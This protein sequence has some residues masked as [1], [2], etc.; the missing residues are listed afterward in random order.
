M[1]ARQNQFTRLFGGAALATIITAI[2]TPGFAQPQAPT[3][4][5]V[6]KPAADD[7]A[8]AEV[9]V[10]G[11]LIR[12]V[13]PVGTNVTGV[14]EQQ[15]QAMGATSPQQILAQIPAVTNQF[16]TAPS[17]PTNIGLSTQRPNIRNLGASGGNTT[18]VLVDGHNLVG[19]GILQTTPDS[20]L[21]PV[22]ALQRVEVMAD[23]GSSLYGADAVGGIV[24][25][26]TKRSADGLEVQGHYG[27]ADPGY[28][29]A[30]LGATAGRSWSN[31]SAYISASHRENSDLVASKRNLPRQDF[32]PFGG[33]DFRATACAAPNITVG[34]VNYAGPGFS[35]GTQNRC[36]AAL[37]SDIVPEEK[38]DSVFAA[39]NQDFGD[40]TNLFVTTYWADR[41]SSVA[42]TQVSATG[43]AIPTTNPFFRPLGPGTAQTASLD[44]APVLGPYSY[45]RGELSEYGVT[46]TLTV[47]LG[48]DWEVKGMINYGRSET[49]VHT[50]SVNASALAA[51]GAGTTTATALNPYD[52]RQTN[53]GVIAAIT[54]FENHG[55]NV[56]ALTEYRVIAEGPVL[57]LPGG[58]V[59]MALGADY[60]HQ[61]SDALSGNNTPGNDSTAATKRASRNVSAVFG[62]VL[63]PI[64]GPDNALP[65]VQA[66]T[67][68]A[69]IRYDDY[70]DFGDTTNPKIG[71][72][73][74][75]AGGVSL[76][77][78]YGTAFNAP[79]LA[80]TTGA[81]DSRAAILSVSP[82]RAPTSP[83]TDLFRPTIVLAGGNP[84]L[85][86]Q[87]ADTWSVGVDWKPSYIA[88]FQ[89][90]LT[91]WDVK[92]DDTIVV[93]PPGFPTSV[94][95]VPA[96]QQ[97]AVV[98]PTLAQAQAITAGMIVD[99][100]PSIASLYTPFSSPYVIL[101]LRRKNVGTL[102]VS[103]L[104]FYANYSRST[105]FGALFAN[106]SGTYAL[107]RESE[108]PSAGRTDL[109]ASNTSRLQVSGTVGATWGQ[110]TASATMNYSAG[111]DVT[112]LGAQTKVDDFHPVNL[113]FIYNFTGDGWGKDLQFT[114]NI[115]NVL[116]DEIPFVNSTSGL[117]SNGRTLGR[118]VNLGI[119]KH[120]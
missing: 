10:T 94:F 34:G 84:D 66:F 114:L 49:E 19:A 87:T 35:A 31:G 80:D 27:L 54:N 55:R 85:K 112:G 57:T 13:A 67:L 33:D 45:S 30:D 65:F 102:Y 113:A 2:S 110:L 78:N 46:P 76:R 109:L 62:Q 77:G 64:V 79:S 24:N 28:W 83:I 72:T 40:R 38:Q 104:D 111:F 93:A 50:P 23:G 58:E 74:E 20:D 36:D 103:G 71:F 18:L 100:A 63:V 99:G 119:R 4:T 52:V 89:A 48:R 32:R 107:N 106:V 75:V 29:A 21:L 115:D 96:F 88:G 105:D 82:F 61:T 98:N 41:K 37:F 16:N 70:S 68:D 51:A 3:A 92:L 12:G 44:F 22:G 6:S 42:S 60:Q 97:F 101:D 43:V 120:F 95:T 53:P 11:T 17:T 69:S 90:G 118:F 9:V 117:I 1:L 108:A 8:V 56:Q 5:P 73:W 26:I 59:R 39:L 81:V 47:K 7:S 116:D 91:Y 15:I 25:F 86:P 14:N